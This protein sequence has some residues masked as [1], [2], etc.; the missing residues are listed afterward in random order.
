MP[1]KRTAAKKKIVV[2]DKENFRLD[3]DVRELLAASF[4][5]VKWESKSHAF[6][7]SL[8]RA[9]SPFA[10][11]GQQINTTPFE[12]IVWAGAGRRGAK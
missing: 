10:L 2:R 1:V 5:A 6:N 11:P 9:L 8:R 7:A 12:Q 4:I 3:D